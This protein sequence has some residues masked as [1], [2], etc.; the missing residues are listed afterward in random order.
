MS[1]DRLFTWKN[2]WFA[3]SVG[4]AGAMAVLSLIVGFAGAAIRHHGFAAG[5]PVGRHLQRRR[6]SPRDRRFGS[7]QA[8]LHDIERRHEFA[9]VR[10]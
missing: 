7:S 6:R 9:D 2:P 5:E 10:A 1:T 3:A 4:I 8:G